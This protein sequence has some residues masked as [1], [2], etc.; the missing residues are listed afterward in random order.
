[1]NNYEG[2]LIGLYN[3]NAHRVFVQTAN[4]PQ[5]VVLEPYED[6]IAGFEKFTFDELRMINQKSA[7]IRNG[8]LKI[9]EEKEEG[10]KKLL[11]IYEI[12]DNDWTPEEIRDCVLNPTPQKLETL[13]RITSTATL[14]SFA[15][16]ISAEENKKEFLMSDHVREIVKARKEELLQNI[17]KSDIKVV[18]STT[19]PKTVSREE[20][21][22][23]VV[24]EVAETKP[25]AKKATPA[26]KKTPPKKTPVK[27]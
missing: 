10:I 17:I 5:G 7:V 16:V 3:Y 2:Q 23:K 21:T 18:E 11:G 12:S 20:R 6:G 14:D 4:R 9:E 27:K 1:M 8:I 25:Q 26:P 19:P 13:K 24:E 15:S 22:N